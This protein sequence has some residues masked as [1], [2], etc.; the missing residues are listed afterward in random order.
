M[1][2]FYKEDPNVGHIA[3]WTPQ[4]PICGNVSEPESWWRVEGMYYDLDADRR[5]ELTTCDQCLNIL[6]FLTL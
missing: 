4:V 3:R 1:V 5:R 6:D 2:V